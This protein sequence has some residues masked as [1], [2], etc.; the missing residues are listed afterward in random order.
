MYIFVTPFITATLTFITVCLI[1]ITVVHSIIYNNPLSIS[2]YV[3]DMMYVIKIIIR[4]YIYVTICCLHT[5]N[6]LTNKKTIE[7]TYVLE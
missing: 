2:M 5:L 1:V 3:R 6:V 7:H 4:I